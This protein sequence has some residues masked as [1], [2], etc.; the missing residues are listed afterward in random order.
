[1]V[2]IASYFR[3]P[4]HTPITNAGQDGQQS[5]AGIEQRQNA[6]ALGDGSGDEKTQHLS[7]RNYA[8]EAAA[9]APQHFRRRLPLHQNLSGRNDESDSKTQAEGGKRGCGDELQECHHE[10]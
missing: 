2:L 4:G 7:D 9:D 1:M 3:N 6:N 5:S 10:H 8:H